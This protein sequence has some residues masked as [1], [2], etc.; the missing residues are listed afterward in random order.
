MNKQCF[1]IMSFNEQYDRVYHQGIR[2]AVERLGY[3]CVRADADPGPANVPAEI[4]RAIIA[5]DL[6][7]ADVSEPSPNVFYE[8]G[9]S[10]CVGNKTIT[11]TSKADG[12]PF[13]I[14][15][16]RATLYRS[17]G[18]G[19][20][21]LAHTIGEIVR[22]MQ[23]SGMTAPNNLAQ[24]A[25]RHYFDLRSQLRHR[26]KE[27]EAERTRVHAFAQFADRQGTLQDNSIVARKVVGHIAR[28]LPGGPGPLLVS[29]GGSGAVG[30]STFAA[31]VADEFRRLHGSRFSVEIL[32]TDSY[33]ME[34][35]DR[36]LKNLIGFDARAHD[37]DQMANDVE[38]LMTGTEVEVTPYDHRTGRH[39]DARVVKPSDLII[40][41]GVYSF[42]P[43]I[44]PFNSG[45]RYYIYTPAK[46]A[47]ELKFIADFTNRGYDIQ[48]AFAH[49]DAEYQAYEA[50]ILPFLR[51]AD[52][53]ITVDD[54]WKYAGLSPQEFRP[55][56]G[57]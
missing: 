47:K 5:A 49:A 4:I 36:I 21:L 15:T 24:E 23:S 29:I 16:F 39:L 22:S 14:G 40:L 25:G 19:L 46:Q 48:E 11:I 8:L 3:S 56:R 35:A 32:P 12:L 30:K 18:D 44:A 10:H 55:L 42:Y 37:L 50:H 7:I 26:M 27:V 17:H 34:R 6:V 2:P 45:L 33:Q 53:V 20:K 57:Q 1:V 41:E 28:F 38:A 9:V 51:F 52:F 54:Y 31:L 43:L 13:D